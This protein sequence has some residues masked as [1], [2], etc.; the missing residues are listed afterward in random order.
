MDAKGSDAFGAFTHIPF[1]A[2]K[3]PCHSC[4]HDG[5]MRT[6]GNL[7]STAT[8]F[9]KSR[10]EWI[11]QP[12]LDEPPL[13]IAGA[14][15][16]WDHRVDEDHHQQPGDLFRKMNVVQRQILFDNTTRAVG[17]DAVDIQER[18]VANCR[19]ADPE[20]RAGVAAVLRRM[21]PPVIGASADRRR[22]A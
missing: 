9:P 18:H 12:D 8:Y 10:G 16:H 17:G 13:Q 7:G 20:Y 14:A 11:D 5:A 15:A 4:H 6:D 3:W 2:P 1:D 21:R 19:K 22:S